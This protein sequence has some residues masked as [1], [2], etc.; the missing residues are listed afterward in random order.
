MP[1]TW[2]SPQFDSAYGHV[3]LD[4]FCFVLLLSKLLS[5]LVNKEGLNMLDF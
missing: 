2:A 5:K 1:L 4:L 3:F